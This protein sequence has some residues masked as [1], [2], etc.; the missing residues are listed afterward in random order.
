MEVSLREHEMQVKK[1]KLK[2]EVGSKASLDKEARQRH[3][4]SQCKYV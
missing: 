3:E 4:V 2:V 1:K